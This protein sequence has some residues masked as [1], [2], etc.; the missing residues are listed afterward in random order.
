MISYKEMV[1]Q[2]LQNWL[3][4]QN[5]SPTNSREKFTH[6]EIKSNYQFENYLI[7]INYKASTQNYSV[8]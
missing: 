1:D 5:R 3:E 7:G 6:K 4:T 2:Y 8:A